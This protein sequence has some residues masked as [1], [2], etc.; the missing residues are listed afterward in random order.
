[1][2]L[3]FDKGEDGKLMP[4]LE[5]REIRDEASATRTAKEMAHRDVASSPGRAR[6][7]WSTGY[8]GEPVVLFQNGEGPQL[9]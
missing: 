2:L 7:T 8:S 9:A 3:A 5:P 4:A 1:M 6:P